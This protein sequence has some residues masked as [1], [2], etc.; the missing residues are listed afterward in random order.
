MR[1][2]ALLLLSLA[3]CHCCKAKV[4]LATWVYRVE[5]EVQYEGSKP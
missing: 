3:G 2:I 5:V 1:W 4:S